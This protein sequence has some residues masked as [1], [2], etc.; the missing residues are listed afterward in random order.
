MLTVRDKVKG[1]IDG[2]LL[3]KLECMQWN[4]QVK[5][6]DLTDTKFDS[7]CPKDKCKLSMILKDYCGINCKC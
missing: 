4:C 1:R 5:C 3:N 2:F 6:I 7:L